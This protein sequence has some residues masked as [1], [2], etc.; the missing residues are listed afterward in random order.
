MR[1]LQSVVQMPEGLRTTHSWEEEAEFPINST[2]V[3]AASLNSGH[4]SEK[5]ERWWSAILYGWPE[6]AIESG[7]TFGWL[8]GTYVVGGGDDGLGWRETFSELGSSTEKRGQ[9]IQEVGPV[10]RP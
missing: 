10:R 2:S 4:F 3:V 8:E 5:G 6:R 7:G 9:Q 1:E